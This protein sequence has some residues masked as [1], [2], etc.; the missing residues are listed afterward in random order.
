V[1]NPLTNLVLIAVHLH[2]T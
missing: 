1:T 2:L